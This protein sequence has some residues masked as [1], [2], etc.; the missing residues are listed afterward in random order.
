M[1][2]MWIALTILALL[3]GLGYPIPTLAGDSVWT[4]C[5]Q[6]MWGGIVRALALS[7]GYAA[8]R[9]LFAGTLG[10]GGRVFKSTDGG[11]SWSAMGL[12]NLGA[13]VLALSPNYA[14]DRTLFAGTYR[15]V[16][17]S[18]DG[19][20]SWSAVNTGLTNLSVL[21]L[22]LSPGYTTDRTLFAGTSGGGVFR[23]T[24]GG[25][26]WGD[27]NRG[28]GNLYIPS[29]ALTPTFPRTLFAGTYGSSVWQY[30]LPM[31]LMPLMPYHL[32]LPLVLKGYRLQRGTE[33][34]GSEC[35]GK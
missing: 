14:T 27:M 19:G 33:G 34:Q 11:A 13:Y 35:P 25:A 4:Q 21:A 32:P 24:D 7:P 28:L 3:A 6:G 8:D 30:T 12:A 29:L 10:V 23:F 26:S 17:Q 9:T 15:G 1:K 22:A 20:A 31:P 18:A 2:R 5:S 16:F